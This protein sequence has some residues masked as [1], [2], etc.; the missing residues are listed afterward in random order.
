MPGK[1]PKANQSFLKVG[2]N[3]QTWWNFIRYTEEKAH[4]VLGTCVP[5]HAKPT[6]SLPVCTH[7]HR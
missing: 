5:T 3:F 4:A 7:V 1:N 2:F 6:G